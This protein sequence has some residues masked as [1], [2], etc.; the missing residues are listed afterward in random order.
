MTRYQF[1]DFL[2]HLSS[3]SPTLLARFLKKLPKETDSQ[4]FRALLASPKWNHL[5]VVYSDFLAQLFFDLLSNQKFTLP[6]AYHLYTRVH[7]ASVQKAN[8]TDR[9][10]RV[11]RPDILASFGLAKECCDQDILQKGKSVL[12]IKCRVLLPT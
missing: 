8:S 11:P 2:C 5:F 6:A 1:L 4:R 9:F 12:M 3:Q 7:Q 10:L